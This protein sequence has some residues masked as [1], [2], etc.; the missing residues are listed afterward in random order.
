MR[1]ESTPR[2]VSFIY[3]G[4][5]NVPLS[6]LFE[7]SGHLYLLDCTFDESL[8]EYPDDYQVFELPYALLSNLPTDW[9]EL[10]A[11]AVRHLGVVPVTSVRLDETRRKKLDGSVLENVRA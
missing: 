5:Y 4:F 9:G 10:P 1:E 7:E 6:I 2:W 11:L 3:R 8:D